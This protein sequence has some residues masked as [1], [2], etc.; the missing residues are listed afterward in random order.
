MSNLKTLFIVD[1]DSKWKDGRIDSKVKAFGFF[2]NLYSR[3]KVRNDRLGI[4]VS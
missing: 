4:H 3:H 2:L 1:I